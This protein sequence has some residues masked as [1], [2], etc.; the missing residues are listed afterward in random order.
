VVGNLRITCNRLVEMGF[1]V[2]VL[3]TGHYPEEQMRAVAQVARKVVDQHPGITA[4]GLA[5]PQA[6]PNEFRGDHAAKWET[7]IAL[8]LMPE[9]V[10]MEYFE[11]KPEPLHGI[12]GEDPR[13]NASVESGR[14]TVEGITETVV[15]RVLQALQGKPQS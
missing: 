10:H 15:N 5:E 7:S 13:A 3:L 4:I 6:Y 14:E 9:L 2:L 8:Y 11:G 1:K 12:Y